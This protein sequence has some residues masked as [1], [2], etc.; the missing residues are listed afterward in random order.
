MNQAQHLHDDALQLLK[1]R[2]SGSVSI[3]DD[4]KYDQQRRPWL[5]VIDQHPWAIVNARTTKDIVE[6]IRFARERKVPLAV[7]NTGHGIVR[8]CD[9]GILLRLS[10]MKAIQVDEAAQ[11]ATVEPGVVSGELLDAIEPLG[12]AFPTGQVS[13]VGVTGYTLGGGIGW[14]SRKYGPAC[15][16]VKAAT[17]VLADGTVLTATATENPDLFWALRGGGETSVLLLP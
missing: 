2:V 14:L 17:V 5:D 7:Q 12:F 13:N 3:L 15:H 6:T 8:A 1:E 9:S 11:T 16:A 10:E 4:P